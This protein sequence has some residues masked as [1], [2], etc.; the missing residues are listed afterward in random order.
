[1]FEH[2]YSLVDINTLFINIDINTLFIIINTTIINH[3]ITTN[4]YLNLPGNELNAKLIAKSLILLRGIMQS[5]VEWRSL[6]YEK[7]RAKSAKFQTH[8]IMTF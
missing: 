3:N 7:T 2:N 6:S 4:Y 5:A 1:M 8:L